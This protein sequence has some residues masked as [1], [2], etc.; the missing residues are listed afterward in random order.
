MSALPRVREREVDAPTRLMLTTLCASIAVI[1]GLTSGA[2][3]VVPDI[4]RDLGGDQSDLQLVSDV[5]PV[6]VAALLLP[7]GALLDRYGR[8]RGMLIGLGILIAAVFWTALASSIE[9]V[10]ISRVLAGV[11]AALLFP[12]TLATITAVIPLARRGFAVALWAVSVV[13]GA[14]FGLLIFATAGDLW[15]WRWAFVVV[16]VITVV[17][18]VLTF[19]VVPETRAEREVS[20]DPIGALTSVGAI[21][22]LVI[23]VTEAPVHG[24]TG[25]RTLISGAIGL[26][27][28]VVFVRWEL[29]RSHPLLDVRLMLDGR[30]G[31]GVA[32]LFFAFFAH[33]AMYFLSIVYQGYVLGYSTIQCAF[34]VALPAMGLAAT[35][36]GL[37]LSRRYGRRVVITGAL[38]MCAAGALVAAGMA[39]SDSRSYWTFAIGAGVIWTGVAIAMAPPTEMITESVPMDK[40][41]VA[42]AVNDLARELAAACGIAVGGSLFNTYYRASVDDHLVGLPP[43]LGDLVLG[44]PAAAVEAVD[45]TPGAA[46]ILD[47][48]HDGVMAGWVGSLVTVAAV[49]VVGA[50]LVAWRCP[51]AT[52]DRRS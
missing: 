5:F 8:R 45:G 29:R 26:L 11:G 32:T 3:A 20:F 43:E 1:M 14:V 38:L 34:G 24:W 46:G 33:F 17:L 7:A 27:L 42:S 28:L 23:A 51:A 31:A 41:G 47:I 2:M 25:T 19:A 48:V 6:V 49:S 9:A 30:F 21:G 13:A 52:T 40:Q 35:P 18:T 36:L 44:S 10:I 16:A 39:L 50:A 4:G 15:S 22:G 37:W 12:G